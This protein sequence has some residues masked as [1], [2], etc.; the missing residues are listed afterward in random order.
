MRHSDGLPRGQLTIG[1]LAGLAGVSTRTVRHYHAVGLL[2]EPERDA[3]GYRRYAAADVVALVRIVR[4]RAVGMPI[5]RIAAQ[6][7]DPVDGLGELRRLAEELREEIDR[8]STLHDRLI[9]MTEQAVP[10]PAEALAHALRD[11]GRL[12]PDTALSRSEAAATELVDALHPGGVSGV[13]DAMSA[14][15][16]DPARANR[17]AELIHRVQTLPDDADDEQLDQLVDELVSVLP[18]ANPA[19]VPV[20]VPTLEKLLGR[21]LTDAQRRFHRR[22]HAALGAIR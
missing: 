5:S 8:L 1:E 19:P 7:K 11:A 6:V 9:Q 20:D 2:P 16:A 14:V 21:R 22:M 15:L 3:S 4:L 12:P 17:L 10:G 13:L 18:R